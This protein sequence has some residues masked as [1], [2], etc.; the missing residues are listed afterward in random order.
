MT[1][2]PPTIEQ[3]RT[4]L[5]RRRVSLMTRRGEVAKLLRNEHVDGQER[6][7][8]QEE[9]A[10]LTTR[11]RD[12]ENELAT[13]DDVQQSE[14]ADRKAAS[15]AKDAGRRGVAAESARVA[16]GE[17]ARGGGLVYHAITNLVEAIAALRRAE[18]QAKAAGQAA[19]VGADAQEHFREQF[20]LLHEIELE[21]LLAEVPKGRLR[22]ELEIATPVNHRCQRALAALPGRTE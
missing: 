1:A 8:L 18:A 10:D 16:L 3:E 15:I 7:E 20:P 6:R 22:A 4:E 21:K 9:Q 11:I 12:V 2:L 19:L 5:Q 14:E 13:L 17:V